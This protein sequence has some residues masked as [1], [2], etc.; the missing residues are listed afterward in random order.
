MGV[1][2]GRALLA[3]GHDLT[4]WNR[5]AMK[6]QPLVA[7]GAALA[8]SLGSAFV[9]S[10]LVILCL[11]DYRT[12]FL[13]LESASFPD[14]LD[15]RTVAQFSIGTPEEADRLRTWVESRGAT[16]LDGF[17]KAYP[18]EI[19]TPASELHVSGSPDAFD[20]WSPTLEAMGS[21]RFIGPDV[22]AGTRLNNAGVAIMEASLAAFFESARYAV[23]SGID[24]DVVVSTFSATMRL[25]AATVDYSAKEFLADPELGPAVE[26]SI[27]VH[28]N[29]LRA[30]LE[31]LAADGAE[32]TLG[33]AALARFAEAQDAGWGDR[34]MTALLLSITP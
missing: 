13:A 6:A 26:A 22:A 23:R 7:E 11:L 14:R 30:V 29:S 9:G 28:A 16:Y 12:T 1:A 8:D 33:R 32:H 3:D 24:L 27:D 25:V 4:V 2:L 31:A 10:E 5:T 20:R 21:S 34:E 19:G 18:R 17:I 15:G